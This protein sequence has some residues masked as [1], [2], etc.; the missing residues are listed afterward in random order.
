MTSKL[1][2]DYER[3]GY[4]SKQDWGKKPALLLVDF[5]RAYFEA[6]SPLFGGD[7]CI[8][9]VSNVQHLL[10]KARGASIPVIFTEVRYRK[11]GLD[12]GIF[13]RKVPPLACFE[14]DNPF[15]D[16]QPPLKRRDNETMITKQYPSAFFGT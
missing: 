11:G 4:H 7:G 10:E 16:L 2:T 3:A 1:D 5:A 13:F 15:A 14:D 8:N 9:A 6:D 12:G